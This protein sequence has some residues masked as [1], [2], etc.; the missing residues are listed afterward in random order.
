MSHTHTYT[1]TEEYYSPVKKKKEI[2][3]FVTKWV[4]PEGIMSSEN[5]SKKDKY[6]MISF[7]CGIK[8]NWT[9]RNRVDWC[10][11][12]GREGMSEGGVQKVTKLEL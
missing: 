11:G 1:H 7:I 12:A 10:F 8:K 4:N 9:H 5:K 6:L 2:L 3:L